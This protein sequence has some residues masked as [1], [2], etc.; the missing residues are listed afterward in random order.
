LKYRNNSRPDVLRER[1]QTPRTGLVVNSSRLPR[2]NGK[3][4]QQQVEQYKVAQQQ[5]G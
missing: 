2:F 5:A 3:L 1:R 4:F